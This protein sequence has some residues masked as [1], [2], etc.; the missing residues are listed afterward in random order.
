MVFMAAVAAAT[1]VIVVQV[2]R[3]AASRPQGT[4]Q[5]PVA[6]ADDAALQLPHSAAIERALVEREP[7]P[8]SEVVQESRHVLADHWVGTDRLAV[9][10]HGESLLDLALHVQLLGPHGQPGRDLHE[11]PLPFGQLGAERCTPTA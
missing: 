8:N 9:L 1:A 11:G 4:R 5:R 6:E 7:D 10:E 3:Q 2:G